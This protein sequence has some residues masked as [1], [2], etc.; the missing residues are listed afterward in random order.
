MKAISPKEWGS[1]G[2]SL[3]HRMSFCFTNVKEAV[4]FYKT[5]IHI[6][7]CPKCRKNMNDH[8]VNLRVPTKI[9]SFPEWVWQLHN[10]VSSSIPDKEIDPITFEEVRNKYIYTCHK[11]E[12]CE[13]KFLLAIAETHPGGKNINN[14]YVNSLKI[15]LTIFLEKSFSNK[16]RPQINDKIFNSRASLR[17]WLQKLTKT[18]E[19][20]NECSI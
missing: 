14:E 2:W 3:L 20:F 7:P 4:S 13:S 6:L 16:D 5:L 19:H 1:S 15:F 12:P 17:N 18:R 10:R 8:F 11:L 9:K